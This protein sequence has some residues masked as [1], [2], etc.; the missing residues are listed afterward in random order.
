MLV[1]LAGSLQ[2]GVYLCSLQNGTLKSKVHGANVP[3]LLESLAEWV[4]PLPGLDDLEVRQ[5]LG[6]VEVT[7]FGSHYLKVH[8]A[9]VTKTVCWHDIL[10]R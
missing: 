8:T 9:A 3:C 5:C 10:T 4:T 2:N 7:F 6:S 1:Y